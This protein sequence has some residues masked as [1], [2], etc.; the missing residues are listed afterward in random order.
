MA[1][2][3]RI[4]RQLEVGAG[5][6]LAGIGL[7]MCMESHW[8]KSTHIGKYGTREPAHWVIDAPWWVIDGIWLLGLLVAAVVG[9]RGGFL[10][11]KLTAIAAFLMLFSA[12]AQVGLVMTPLVLFVLGAF[13]LLAAPLVGL[14]IYLGR[15]RTDNANEVTNAESP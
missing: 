11:S 3:V 1:P 4:I 7:S 13:H 9:F 15:E 5:C 8:S 12:M 14:R 6:V 10:G 2:H